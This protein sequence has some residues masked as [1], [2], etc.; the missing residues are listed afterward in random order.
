MWKRGSKTSMVGKV[1]REEKV[2]TINGMNRLDIIK[3]ARSE[4]RLEESEKVHHRDNEERMP[5]NEIGP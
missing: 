2:A 4:R 5:C 1:M 3:E